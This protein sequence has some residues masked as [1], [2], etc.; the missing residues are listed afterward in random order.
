[1]SI[2]NRVP[3][4]KALLTLIPEDMKSILPI[5]GNKNRLSLKCHACDYTTYEDAVLCTSHA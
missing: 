3:T 1:M 2:C 5:V 4:G